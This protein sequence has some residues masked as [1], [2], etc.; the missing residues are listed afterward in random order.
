MNKEEF[1][2]K[3]PEWISQ[4]KERWNHI[5][6]LAYFCHKYEEKNGV[7]FS[8][9]NWKANPGRSKESRDFSKLFVEFSPNNYSSLQKEQKELVR[10]DVNKKI[11]NYIN[12]MF[13]FKFRSGDKSVTG[14]G[15]FLLKSIINE[16][17]RMYQ[18]FI[19]KKEADAVFAGFFKWCQN[20]EP[21]IFDVQQINNIDD[22]MIL[23]KYIQ[24]YNLGE[25]DVEYRVVKKAGEVGLL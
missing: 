22:L 5:T 21:S 9:S 24:M 7:R 1:Y 25:S 23:S 10:L 15:I 6:L 11:Y 3:I 4:P 14:T 18:S 12:W 19:K 16:F 20:E 13:D 8:L 2:R 17:E